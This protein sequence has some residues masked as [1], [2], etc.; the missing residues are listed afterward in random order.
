MTSEKYFALFPYSFHDGCADHAKYQDGNLELV[1]MRCPG[2]PK[3]DEDKNSRYLKLMFTNVTDF[4]IWDEDKEFLSDEHWEE[5]WI[6]VDNNEIISTLSDFL[7]NYIGESDFIDGRVVFDEC[8]R[9]RC[10][11]ITVLESR[12]LRESDE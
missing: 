4:W 3:N 9:F 1:I 7:P 6:S 12:E 2:Y 10:D 8:I 5:M 11:D